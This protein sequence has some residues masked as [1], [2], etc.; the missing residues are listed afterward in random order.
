MKNLFIALPALILS[1]ASFAASAP[2]GCA[3]LAQ[4]TYAT[5]IKRVEA[6]LALALDRC[7]TSMHPATDRCYQI[8]ERRFENAERS[9]KEQLE[10]SVNLCQ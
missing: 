2:Q 5:T 7:G 3:E 9:A 1:T 4:A 10:R 8:A 6:E